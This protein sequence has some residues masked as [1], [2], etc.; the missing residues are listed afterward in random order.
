MGIGGG[1]GKAGEIEL[2]TAGFGVPM[3]VGMGGVR[4]Q[5]WVVFGGGLGGGRLRQV[6][7]VG[8]QIEKSVAGSWSPEKLPLTC[9][10][11]DREPDLGRRRREYLKITLP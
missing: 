2:Q 6:W 10:K 11:S 7:E 8:S 3:E 1:R 9:R 4:L 5:V